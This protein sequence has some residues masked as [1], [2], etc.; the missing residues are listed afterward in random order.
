M[1]EREKRSD[2][3]NPVTL[4]RCPNPL[5]VILLYNKNPR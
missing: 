5:A 4:I 3:V 1:S 2:P